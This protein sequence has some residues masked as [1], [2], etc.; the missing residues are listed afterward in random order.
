[1]TY[2]G[3]PGMEVH[4]YRWG[5]LTRELNGAGFHVD[6]VVPIDRERAEPIH[7][8]WLLHPV[9]AGGWLVFASRPGGGPPALERRQ[10][11]IF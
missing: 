10:T 3:I 8:P 9:R 2:R 4:L 5:E 7:A 1:M 11:H 6:E